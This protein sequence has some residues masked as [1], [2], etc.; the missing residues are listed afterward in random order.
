MDDI[1]TMGAAELA[2]AVGSRQMSAR[3]VA[4]AFLARTE[5]V[6][7][8][9]NAVCTLNPAA[10]AEAEACD[11]RLASGAAPRLLEGVPFVVKD[12]V[13]TAGLR[14]TY[15]S[16]LRQDFVPAEDA[17]AVE[18]LR[19][20]GAVLLGK[21]NAP[22]FAHDVNTTNALFGTTRNPWRLDATSGGSSGGTG[23]A[24]AAGMAPIGIGT[25]LGGSIR[26]PAAFNG[27][28]GVRPT[29]G[30]VP[31]Y[32]SAF[33]WDT[34]V[35]HVQ[36]PLARSVE[37]A[38]LMLAVMAGPDD[39][40]PASL[41]DDGMDLAAA[42]RRTDT[43][44]GRR[45]LYVE[46]FG[47]LV[48]TDPEVARLARAAALAFEDLG[49]VVESGDL[50][51]G[52]DVGGLREI[53]MGTRA[54]GMVGRYADLLDHHRAEM[55][56][57]LVNQIED[58]LK[59][60]VREVAAAERLRGD[61]WHRVR[62]VLERFDHIIAPSVGIAAFD[63][64]RPLPTEIAGR[65]LERFYDVFLGTYAFSVTGLPVVAVP[66]GFTSAGLPVGVQIV[67]RRLRDDRALEAAAA[68]AQARPEHVRRPQV[69]TAWRP[70]EH[71]ETGTTGYKVA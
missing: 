53:V 59:R 4:E 71:G 22:E 23:A 50:A 40:D 12:N 7:G 36:G 62:R 26:V 15:G 43:V 52:F 16:R 49:C 33:A 11:A 55:T 28:V 46:D 47:G 32:P 8:V 66:C 24:V 34:L 35:E 44:R 30:R 63:L 61:Y 38:G 1:L 3:T 21:T 29:P 54:F 69:D 51:A 20:A 5:A 57:P 27:I 48:P 37:D 67:G 31:V 65:P 58:A 13:D 64:D 6:N 18:R 19:R 68:F 2:Q 39:R 45:I 17:V 41:P 14:T 60:S 56:A 42:A 10:L 25:D 70:P 9:V